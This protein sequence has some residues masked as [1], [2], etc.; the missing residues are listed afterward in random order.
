MGHAT[1][2]PTGDDVPKAVGVPGG[3]SGLCA[4]GPCA[5]SRGKAA[6]SIPSALLAINS[7]RDPGILSFVFTFI[8]PAKGKLERIYRCMP[9]FGSFIALF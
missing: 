1:A 5:A 9:A 6:P 8:F 3:N 4:P 7:L 2:A